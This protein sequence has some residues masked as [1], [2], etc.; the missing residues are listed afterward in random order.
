MGKI[1][2][3]QCTALGW[4]LGYNNK[5]RQC[6]LQPVSGN[7]VSGSGFNP[8]FAKN[9]GAADLDMDSEEVFDDDM[10]EWDDSD[11]I[12]ETVLICESNGYCLYEAVNDMY[13]S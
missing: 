8:E 7:K 5:F 4:T 1:H 9:Y 11:P 13:E 3:I 12:K 10:F 6:C 2:G